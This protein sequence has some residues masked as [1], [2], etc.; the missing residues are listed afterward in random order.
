MK[1]TH[2]EDPKKELMSKVGDLSGMSLFGPTVLMATYLR[3]AKTKSGIILTEKYRDEDIYQGKIGLVL[4]LGPKAFSD[5]PWFGEK[6]EVGDWVWFRASNG[7]A[8]KVN[9]VD[10]RYMDDIHVQGKVAQPDMI[11]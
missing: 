3:P 11:W 8:L 9:E 5:E 7:T 10:C 6:V 1:M 2:E 4:K